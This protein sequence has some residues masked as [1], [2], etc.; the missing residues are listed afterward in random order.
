MHVCVDNEKLNVLYISKYLEWSDAFFNRILPE[1]A[2][3]L[4]GNTL[5]MTTS[6]DEF[7][8]RKKSN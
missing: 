7:L 6:M 2:S 4:L 1:K 8:G 3:F 5:G